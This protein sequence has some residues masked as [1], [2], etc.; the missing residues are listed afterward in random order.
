MIKLFIIIF[1]FISCVNGEE[2]NLVFEISPLIDN[3]I[4]SLPELGAANTVIV[5]VV[6]D[7]INN[8]GNEAEPFINLTNITEI[9]NNKTKQMFGDKDVTIWN[10]IRTY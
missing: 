8:N 3:P 5:D 10:S 7:I 1:I 2:D 9:Y 4:L 6:I